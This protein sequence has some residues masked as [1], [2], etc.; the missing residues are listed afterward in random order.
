MIKKV[1][2]FI[3]LILSLLIILFS[4]NIYAFS[5]EGVVNNAISYNQF[6]EE[7]SR[8]ID[9]AESNDFGAMGFDDYSNRIVVKTDSNKKIESMNAIDSVEGFNCWHF[10]QYESVSDTRT[11]I[12]YYESLPNVEY[13]ELDD[14][15]EMTTLSINEDLS[16]YPVFD[17]EPTLDD[18][19][20]VATNA[21]KVV[22]NMQ[23]DGNLPKVTVAVLDTGFDYSH[24]FFDSSRI[25]DSKVNSDDSSENTN[26]SYGHGTFVAGVIYNNTTPNVEISVYKVLGDN[27]GTKSIFK[28]I[29]TIMVAVNDGADVVNMSLGG[30]G[31]LFRYTHFL[32]AVS[33][34]EDK[35][36]P[37]VVASGNDGVELTT[38]IP[39]TVLGA[40]TVAA[41]NQDL[42]PCDFSNYGSYVDIA[43]PGRQINSAIPYKNKLA[44]KING[45]IVYFDEHYYATAFGTSVATPFVSAAVAMLKTK[46][47][48][49]TVND[50]ETI[51]KSTVQTTSSWNGDYGVGIVNFEKMMTLTKTIAPNITLTTEGAVISASAQ[52]KIYYTTDGSIPIEGK[53]QLFDGTPIK[54]LGVTVIKAIA[55]ADGQLQSNVTTRNLRWTKDITVR[56]KGKKTLDLPPNYKIKNCYS[57]KEEVVTVDSNGNITGISIGKA[58]VTVYLEYNQVATYNVTVE[59]E[60]W[61]LFIIYFLFGFLWY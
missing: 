9:D 42:T 8:M 23:N 1:K 10:F 58:T 49:Y 3:S 38:E 6:F 5:E 12:E 53:S 46:N 4:S 56:Y 40:I 61:Q 27:G 59:Y 44:T 54:T 18:W 19:G 34:A 13:V 50:I 51:L 36:V 7:L 31:T 48:S 15:F 43:A 24:S 47:P 26:D 29:Q 37:V 20:S 57:S 21:S 39:A 25:T 60:A 22:Q 52:A 32:D 2:D 30:P 11:A 14:S 28:L 41:V 16:D 45:E 33:Y 17:V 55:C 35:G